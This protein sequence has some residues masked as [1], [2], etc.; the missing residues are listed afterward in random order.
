MNPRLYNTSGELV[1]ILDNVILESAKIKKVING[2]FTFSFEAFEKEL[3]SQYF[4]NGNVITVDNQSFDI[5]YVEKAHEN[6]VTYKISTEHVS[7]RMEDGEGNLYTSYLYFG[8]PLEILT[9]LLA[10]TEF[11]PGT[12]EFTSNITLSV[13]EQITR[14]SLIKYLANYIGGEIAYRDDGFTID[15]LNTIGANN[16]YQ[17]R[18]GKNLKG[19]TKTVD[20]RDT[21]KTYYSIDI[22]RLKNSSAYIEKEL[23]SLEILELGDTIQL[24]DSVINIDEL[25]RV[26]SMEYNPIFE[27]VTSLEIANTIELITDV[28]TEITTN[29]VYKDR[30]YNN[31]SISS[32]YG[33]RA[34]LSDLSARATYGGGDLSMDVGDGLGNYT[35]ALYFDILTGKFKFIGDIEASG[36]I[37]GADF[38]GG[39]I[40]IGSNFAVDNL[41]NMIA[42][43]AEFSGEITSSSIFGGTLFGSKVQGGLY[44]DENGAGGFDIISNGVGYTDYRFYSDTYG[45]GPKFEFYDETAGTILKSFGTEILGFSSSGGTLAQYWSYG[46]YE[47]ATLNDVSG[48]LVTAGHGIDVSYIGDTT[49]VRV[50]ETELDFS[51]E[52]LGWFSGSLITRPYFSSNYCYVDTDGVNV[53]F[54]DSSGSIVAT[55]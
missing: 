19:I 9:D 4:S 28:I 43:N 8:T 37:T 48:G 17:A 16:G 45:G 42:S 55:I 54:R 2:E 35:K 47:V 1:A 33:F 27:I 12:I 51:G 18:F 13:G 15:I 6:E 23:G 7:Y 11:S 46:G 5:T 22:V 21:L 44:T 30:V 20:S 26:I 31:M 36:T 34:E 10:G 40:E 3:K 32:E 49:E 38:I 53:T 14:K 41:G 50:D 29:A 25:N 24:I 52:S 39:T